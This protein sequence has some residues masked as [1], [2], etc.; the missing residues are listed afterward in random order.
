MPR[1]LFLDLN[2]IPGNFSNCDDLICTSSFAYRD[3]DGGSRGTAAFQKGTTLRSTFIRADGTAAV[4]SP[5][6][7]RNPLNS[8]IILPPY[9]N[10]TLLLEGKGGKKGKQDL[11]ISGPLPTPLMIDHYRKE[12][13][14]EASDFCFR[15]ERILG[16]IKNDIQMPHRIKETVFFLCAS[17]VMEMTNL[18]LCT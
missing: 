8:S 17:V 16:S 3:V 11:I 5:P 15:V 7:V 12:A 2:D 4:P 14:L 13:C 9:L 1:V 18:S 6:L 10:L